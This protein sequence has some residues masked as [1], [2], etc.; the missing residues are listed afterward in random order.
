MLK[1]CGGLVVPGLYTVSNSKVA[2]SPI[3]RLSEKNTKS[4]YGSFSVG[5]RNMVY[6]EGSF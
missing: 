4:V 6:V 3:E 5:Y 1:T 2:K